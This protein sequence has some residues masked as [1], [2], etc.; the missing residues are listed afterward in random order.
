MLL[1]PEA[2]SGLLIGAR[3]GRSLPGGLP[4]KTGLPAD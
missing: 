3:S 2:E 1:L 4:P